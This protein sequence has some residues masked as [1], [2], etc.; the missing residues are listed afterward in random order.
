[1]TKAY[2]DKNDI[3]LRKRKLLGNKAKEELVEA[4]LGLVISI[5]SRFEA[6]GCERED[7]TEVGKLGLIKAIDGFDEKLG[8]SFSTY[9][10]AVIA[11]EI[12]RF[13]RDD[14]II[15]VS[16]NVKQNFTKIT[17]AKETFEKEN[18]REPKIS[19]ICA[20]CSLSREEVTEA[21]SS[22]LSPVSLQQKIFDENSDVTVEDFL[23]V[24]DEIEEVTTITALHECIS[25]LPRFERNI[26]H[27]RYFKNLTQAEVAK[28]LS[29]SQV[30]VS[31]TEK[32][33][34]ILLKSALS[35]L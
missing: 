4:N 7:L 23:P 3:L 5:A 25:S 6:R 16:R 8:Y 20:L 22:S 34:L 11:G 29:T 15:K 31:R 2:K 24:S 21:I 18:G 10:F 27:L 35:E 32:K 9:A 26:I 1:M 12:K 28:I 14:G 33:A 17:K 19:E 30:T 13:L